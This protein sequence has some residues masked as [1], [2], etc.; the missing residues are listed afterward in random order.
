MDTENIFNQNVDY[1]I[2][3]RDEVAQCNQLEQHLKQLNDKQD[4]L[5]KAVSQ[6]E[7]SIHDEITTT[8]KKRKNEIEKTYDDQLD[9]GRKKIKKAQDEKSKE[10]LERVGQRVDEET[11]DVKE[12]TRQLK[13]EMAT[14]FKKNHVPAFCRS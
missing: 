6:E 2:Q 3:I 11:A 14:L 8:I 10:K 12:N 7:K 13:T 1:L 5:R 9:A 4:K